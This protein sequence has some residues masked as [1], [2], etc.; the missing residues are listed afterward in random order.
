MCSLKIIDGPTHGARRGLRGPDGVS[1]DAVDGDQHLA[2]PRPVPG[3]TTTLPSIFVLN[4]TFGDGIGYNVKLRWLLV[5]I[6]GVFKYIVY[7]LF[8]NLIL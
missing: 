2:R 8:Y 3:N 4:E 7:I 5:N 1:D 6:Y